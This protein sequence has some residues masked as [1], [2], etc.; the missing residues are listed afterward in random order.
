MKLHIKRD[1]KQEK[2]LFGGNKGVNFSLTCNAKYTPAEKEL[3]DKY[4]LGEQTLAE[5]RI[6]GNDLPFFVTVSRLET[7]FTSEIKD[8]GELQE[9]EEKIENA[10]RTLKGYLA[11]ATTFGGERVIDI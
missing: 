9:L 2:G 5:Y 3:I 4:K 7:G 1:Q 11:V 6:K 8:L 10:C